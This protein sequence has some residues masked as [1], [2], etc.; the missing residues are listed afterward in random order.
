[1][2]IEEFFGAK[3]KAA[4]M[5]ALAKSRYIGLPVTPRS[6][7]RI[8]RVN[9]S[10]VYRFFRLLE[11]SKM[12]LRVGKGYVMS[13]KGSELVNMIIDMIPRSGDDKIDFLK[14]SLPDTMY[15]IFTPMF[16]RWFGLRKTLVVIDKRLR[17]KINIRCDLC[18]TIYTTL[19]GR[20]YRFDWDNY[21]SK[22]DPEQGYAD[23]I[24]YDESWEEYIPD[25]L[26]NYDLMDLDEIIERSSAEGR[27]RIA[28]AL[29][30]YK[31]LVGNKIPTKLFVPRIVDKKYIRNLTVMIPYL[32]DNRIIEARNI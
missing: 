3:Y 31:T 22:A 13:D 18:V 17:G 23:L 15:Y 29:T 27:R 7:S 10:F 28:T 21:V 2:L 1:M 9:L 20:K 24:S 14:R 16:Q 8:Y 12:I 6:I 4:V 32:L 19:R 26:L 11:D 5:M 25:I 30:Y